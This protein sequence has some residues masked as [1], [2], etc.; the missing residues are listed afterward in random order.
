MTNLAIWN[1]YK[2]AGVESK[3]QYRSIEFYDWILQLE[4]LER[5]DEL[6]KE[7]CSHGRSTP[8]SSKYRGIKNNKRW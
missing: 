8:N 5:D 2:S 3:I 7:L 6:M 1:N 4:K